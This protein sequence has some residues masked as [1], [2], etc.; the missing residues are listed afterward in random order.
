M[1]TKIEDLVGKNATFGKAVHFRVEKVQ[2]L[3]F[4]IFEDERISD[5]LYKSGSILY[6]KRRTDEIV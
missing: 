1:R 5:V 6:C 4:V 2:D 3:F